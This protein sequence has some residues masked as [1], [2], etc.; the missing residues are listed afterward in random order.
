M[1]S[2]FRLGHTY[3]FH[4]VHGGIR[5]CTPQKEIT[6]EACITGQTL[7]WRCRR[8]TNAP[9]MGCSW[10]RRAVCGHYE[11]RSRNA[12]YKHGKRTGMKHCPGC[13]AEMEGE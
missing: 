11:K 3:V 12:Y 9:G 2:I 13:A 7:C 8:A 6:M 4:R 1:G 5:L 10:S